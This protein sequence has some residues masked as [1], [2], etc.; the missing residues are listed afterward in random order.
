MH[1]SPVMPIKRPRNQ[2]KQPKPHDETA[3]EQ[4]PQS[5]PEAGNTAER[6]NQKIGRVNESDADGEGYETDKSSAV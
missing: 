5:Q 3:N 4:Q 6:E 1:L 2:P